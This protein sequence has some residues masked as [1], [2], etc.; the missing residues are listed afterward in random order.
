MATRWMRGLLERI[1]REPDQNNL[2]KAFFDRYTGRTLLV[3]DGLPQ[4]WL[5]KLVH[6][7]GGGGHF[8]I[9]V[10]GPAFRPGT[11]IRR[12][13]PVQW[14]V[15]EHIL[16]LGLPRP[17]L[18]KVEDRDHLRARHLRRHGG[19]CDPAEVGMILEDMTERPHALLYP[20]EGGF[21]VDWVLDP[22]DN[23][24]DTPYGLI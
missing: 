15:R 9:D 14:L 19:V 13:Y 5:G 3:H 7:P 6:E 16:P 22:E 11:P 10:S 1:G 23:L 24:V 12:L 17:V 18:V 8:R 4:G 2:Q 20:E 21:S